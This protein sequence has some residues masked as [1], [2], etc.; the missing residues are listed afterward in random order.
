MRSLGAKPPILAAER[1]D[2]RLGG[3]ARGH[4]QAVGLEAGAH[5]HPVG[6]HFRAV[7]EG[8]SG[9]GAVLV[10]ARN[11]GAGPDLTARL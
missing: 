11:G 8:D 3:L 10:N 7:G 5:D 4:G 6:F 2:P 9:V 1:H